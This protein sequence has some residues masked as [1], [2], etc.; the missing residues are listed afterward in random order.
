MRLVSHQHSQEQHHLLH[1][2]LSN[3]NF[4]SFESILKIFLN[5][6]IVK[7]TLKSPPI[8]ISELGKPFK[9]LIDVICGVYEFE[10]LI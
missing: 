9:G 4:F 3:C 2:I 10:T 6:I 8:A 1:S 7:T 5:K